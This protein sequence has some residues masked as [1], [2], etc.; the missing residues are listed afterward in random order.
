MLTG[1]ITRDRKPPESRL[2]QRDMPLYRFYF[3]ERAFGIVDELVACAR[4]V[5]CTPG[6]LALAWQLAKPEITS[7]IIGARKESQ[8][9]ENLGATGVDVPPE[10]MQR[11]E[12]ATR[13][14]PE[15][16]VFID[17]HPGLARESMSEKFI[18][19]H[20]FDGLAIG[21][22]LAEWGLACWLLGVPPAWLHLLLLPVL[23]LV[24]RRAA[25][26]LEREPATGIFAGA[27][28]RIVLGAA[29][30]AFASACVLGALASATGIVWLLGA[31][32]A[33]A[34]CCPGSSR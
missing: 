11:L 15:Y 18:F 4:E 14:E 27:T 10:I 23:A 29:F 24:N 30:A 31:L 22:A 5:R 32:S 1:K 26:P 25:G 13:I 9:E 16:R 28:G 6:E 33:E 21:G 20:F 17:F 2:A 7:V 34:E 8:L 3:N 19:R 12:K